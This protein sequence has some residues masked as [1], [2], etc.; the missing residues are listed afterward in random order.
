MRAWW[1]GALSA[2]ALAAATSLL[3]GALLAGQGST[4][5]VTIAIHYSG[6]D[7]TVITVPVGEPVHISLVNRDPIEHEWI[8]GD[9]AVHERHRTGTEPSHAERPTEISI[10]ALATRETTVVFDEPGTHLYICHLPGH[11]AY[12]MV[13]RIVA[14]ER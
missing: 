6:F 10:P 14:V 3:G 13:G 7:P 12:G 11:E 9:A 8:V 4:T 5:E 2:L 1:A